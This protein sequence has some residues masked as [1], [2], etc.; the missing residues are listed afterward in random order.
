MEVSQEAASELQQILLEEY[1]KNLS[2]EET[3]IIGSR[4]IKLYQTLL[5]KNKHNKH[6]T[7]WLPTIPS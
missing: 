6:E 3:G 5:I 7:K 4:L 1:G 2:I